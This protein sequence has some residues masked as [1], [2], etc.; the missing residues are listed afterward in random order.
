MLLTRSNADNHTNAMRT[1]NTSTNAV[2]TEI[3]QKAMSC[4]RVESKQLS[5]C[6][7]VF[8]KRYI[9]FSLDIHATL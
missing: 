1:E 3:Y 4:T 2:R 6:R 5:K 7:S 9:S 8:K